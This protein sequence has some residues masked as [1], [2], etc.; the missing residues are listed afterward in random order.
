MMA[1]CILCDSSDIQNV[2]RIDQIPVYCNQ[3]FATRQESMAVKR[4][5]L[6]LKYCSQCDH[7]YNSD[8]D[9]SL[10]DYKVSYDASLDFSPHF[11]D[12]IGQLAD[13]L[14]HA[15]GLYKKTVVEIACGRG[16]FLKTLAGKAD[17][18]YMG[19]DPSFEG[20]GNVAEN[21]KIFPQYFDQYALDKIIATHNGQVDYAICRHA[22]EHFERPL[23][24]LKDLY[25]LLCKNPEAGVYFEVPNGLFMVR[26][27]SIWDFIYEHVSYFSPRSLQYAF[28]A[29][30]FSIE[31]CHE[32]YQGQFLALQASMKTQ[33]TSVTEGEASDRHIE[34]IRTRFNDIVR[35]WDDFLS[36]TDG[37]TVLWGAGSKGIT[38]LNLI[39]G[40]ERIAA[41]VDIN[42]NKVGKF[43]P[44]TGHEIIDKE[45][46]R[47]IDP[48]TV[49]VMNQVYKKEISAEIDD[50]GIDARVIGVAEGI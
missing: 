46:L 32:S 17:N 45:A 16:G 3:I 8:F 50:L 27:L 29:S 31:R 36:R 12:Y 4:G 11:Q 49:I 26:D 38:F 2:F 33:Y 42:P 19:F 48:S 6:D 5:N 43:T 47:D 22:L 15:N 44:G 10:M 34:S 37:K 18:L 21:I 7:I 24:M 28:T 14:I 35:T 1:K 20:D 9:A 30:G 13:H 39:A 41:V 40:K 23:D 25:K